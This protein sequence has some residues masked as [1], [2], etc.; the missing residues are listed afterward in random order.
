MKDFKGQTK[1][2][3]EMFKAIQIKNNSLPNGW[4][5]AQTMSDIAARLDADCFPTTLQIYGMPTIIGND[6]LP[7]N[8]KGPI[9][10]FENSVLGSFTYPRAT[11]PCSILKNNTGIVFNDACRSWAGY[12]EA[13]L[14]KCNGVVEMG[15]FKYATDL[16]AGTTWAVGG[17]GLLD[18]WNPSGQGF[19]TIGSTDFYSS[20]AYRTNHIVL[21]YKNSKVY[22]VFCKNMDAP[23]LN[24]FCKEKMKFKLALKVDGG[25][26]SAMNGA[27]RFSKINTNM[28][29]GYCV[30]FI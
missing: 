18:Y 9:R 11:T 10:N 14:Y 2:E 22:G 5:G 20:V 24:T 4:I 29:Q 6:L 28:T 3:D 15:E 30:Q 16:P 27:E 17:F 25:K 21:G 1:S 7:F 12:P 13:V 19:K 26:L 23:Q 8:P